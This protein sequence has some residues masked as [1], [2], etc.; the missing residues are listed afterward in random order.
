M[1][2]KDIKSTMVYIRYHLEQEDTRT[3]LEKASRNDM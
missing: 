3:L 2:H 1:G